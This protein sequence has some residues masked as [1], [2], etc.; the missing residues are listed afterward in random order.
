M[1]DVKIDDDCMFEEIRRPNNKLELWEN[2]R[3]EIEKRWVDI[4][5][6]F[7]NEHFSHDNLVILVE[8]TLCRYGSSSEVETVFSVDNDF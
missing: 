2:K 1:P 3:S 4:L 7:R 8:F 6:H 5:N